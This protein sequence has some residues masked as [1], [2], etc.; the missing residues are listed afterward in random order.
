MHV[1]ILLLMVA[2]MA[3]DAS[4]FVRAP[5]VELWETWLVVLGSNGIL[6]LCAMWACRRTMLSLARRPENTGR[7]LRR[8]DLVLTGTR[9]AA[10]ALFIAHVYGLGWLLSVRQTVGDWV[11]LDELLAAAPV[12]ATLTAGWWAYYRID[13]RLRGLVGT[14][15]QYVTAQ[16]RHQMLFVLAPLLAVMAWM[17]VLDRWVAPHPLFAAW[18]QPLMLVGFATV[19]LFTPVM[20]RYLWDTVP[21]PAGELRASLLELCRAHGVRVRQLL[22]WRTWGGMINGAVMGVCGPLRYILLT[23]GLLDRMTSIEIEAVMAH[24]LGH[25][26]RRHMVWLVICALA[27]MYGMQAMIFGGLEWADRLSGSALL[28]ASPWHGPLEAAALGMLVTG[29]WLIFGWVSRRFERQADTFAVAHLSRRYPPGDGS[30]HQ[31]DPAAVEVYCQTL[32][33]VAAMNNMSPDRRSWRHGSIRWRCDYLRSLAGSAIDDCPID[34]TI[35]RICRAAA[36]LLVIVLVY[37]VLPRT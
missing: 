31:V 9:Y 33:R 16:V 11:L 19:F 8:L 25:V 26:R 5:R 36:V 4:S 30:A 7:S 28:G 17:Q 13:Q 12:L 3:H 20:I 14:R 37:D 1:L 32:M 29:W 2:L 35:G 24:E 18:Q 22:L 23:D 21:L 6:A 10:A 34:R 15:L 27:A